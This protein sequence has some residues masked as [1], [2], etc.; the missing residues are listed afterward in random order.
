MPRV[1]VIMEASYSTALLSQI[2]FPPINIDIIA[3]FPLSGERLAGQRMSGLTHTYI[4]PSISRYLHGAN[5]FQPNRAR[6]I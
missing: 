1:L 2:W 5:R 4:R 6:I 3:R